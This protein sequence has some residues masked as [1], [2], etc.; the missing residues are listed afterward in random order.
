MYIDGGVKYAVMAEDVGKKLADFAIAGGSDRGTTNIYIILNADGEIERLCGKAESKCRTEASYSALP[1]QHQDWEILGLA[2]RS[3]DML[4]KQVERLSIERAASLP[5][6]YP[7]KVHFAKIER[8]QLRKL[9]FPIA[10]G[11][12]DRR[13]CEMWRRQDIIDDDPLEFYAKY[14]KCLLAYGRSRGK[15]AAWSSVIKRQE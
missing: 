7:V 5:R 15:G 9:E 2:S 3:V 1:G 10:R 8:A 11:S 13:T 12:S 14:M 4:I 6:D